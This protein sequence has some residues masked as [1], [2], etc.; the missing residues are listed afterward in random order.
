VAGS[1]IMDEDANYHVRHRIV[2]MG[3]HA[4]AGP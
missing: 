1:R 4:F 3:G 2:D